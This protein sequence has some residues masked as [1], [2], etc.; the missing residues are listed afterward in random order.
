MNSISENSPLPYLKHLN[1][2]LEK[3]S[4]SKGAK[5]SSL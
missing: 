1:W 5:Y 2:T 4:D 3:N